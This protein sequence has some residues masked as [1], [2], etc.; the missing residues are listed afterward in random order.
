MVLRRLHGWCSGGQ[1]DCVQEG[2]LVIVRC[3][4]DGWCS[5]GLVGDVHQVRWVI[6]R[7]RVYGWCEWVIGGWMDG[8]HESRRRMFRRVDL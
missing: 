7:W 6:V 1:M 3:R 8:V 4:M 2:R 5:E